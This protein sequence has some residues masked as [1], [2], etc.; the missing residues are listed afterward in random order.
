MRLGARNSHTLG[1]WINAPPLLLGGS[2]PVDAYLRHSIIVWE[3]LVCVPQ[4]LL[5]TYRLARAIVSDDKREGRGEVDVFAILVIEGA[6]AGLS[7]VFA[8]VLRRE[9][10]PLDL[11]LFYL[12][13]V[14]RSARL[15]GR[16]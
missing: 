14:G 15:T 13:W 1:S 11:E 16:G 2:N 9:S 6:Y 12:R 5:T 8:D 4:S 3:S 10:V 7:S